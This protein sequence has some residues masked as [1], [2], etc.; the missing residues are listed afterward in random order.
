MKPLLSFL[1]F[2]IFS[3]KVASPS[4][5]T[6]DT[7]EN[8]PFWEW[9]DEQ[10]QT[11]EDSIYAILYPPVIAQKIDSSFVVDNSII[12]FSDDVI[13]RDNSHVPTSGSIDTSK[14]VGEINIKSGTSQTG[15]KTYEVPI[16]LYPG[17]NNFQPN[18]AL[19]YNSQQGNSLLGRGWN[20]SGLSIIN[21]TGRNRYYN[22]S[23]QRILMDKTDPFILDGNRLIRISSSDNQNIYESEQGNIKAIG[24]VSGDVITYFEV[25]YPNGYKGIFGN[26]TNVQNYLSYPLT[27]LSDLKGNTIEY[28][29]IDTDNHFNISEITYNGITIEFKYQPRQ[30][31]LLYYCV[32]YKLLESNLLKSITCKLASTELGKYSFDYIIS[33]NNESLLEKINYSVG[34]NSFNPLRFYYG[35]GLTATSYTSSNTQL[36]EWY[37]SEDKNMIKA[38]RGRFDYSSGTDGLIVFPNLNP[39]WEHFR[40][41][42]MFQ[43]S[44]KR[45]INNFKGDEKIFLYAGLKGEGVTPMPNLTTGAGFI[46]IICADI[47]G[48]QEDYVIKINNDVYT[49]DNVGAYY[50]DRVRFTI[51]K[52]NLYT[53]LTHLYTRTYQF[54]T[55]YTDADGGKSIQ[56]KFYYTGD[57]NGDGRMEI[58]AVSAHQPFNETSLPSQCYIFD[59]YHDKIIYEK[60]LFEYNVEFLGSRQQDVVASIN[61]TDKLF[62]FDYDGDGKTDI[63]HIDDYGVNIYS[64]RGT[65][66]QLSV[67]KEA[68]YIGL[69][70][71]GLANREI[72][73][74]DFNGDTLTDLLVS[75]LLNSSDWTIYY[76]KGNGQFIKSTFKGIYRADNDIN[77]LVQDVNSDGV[78][79][80]ITYNNNGFD[81]YLAK[82]NIISD[83]ENHTAYTSSESILVP[84]DL[85]TYGNFTQ[86]ISLKEGVVTKYAFSRNDNKENMVTGVMNSLG[87]IEK[88]EYNLINEENAPSGFYTKGNNANFPYI[89]ICEAIPV[90]AS[91]RTYMAG[92][93]VDNNSYT[94]SNAVFHKQ[95]LGFRGFEKITRYNKRGQAC[96]K[97]YTPL[98]N[99]LLISEVSPISEKKYTYDVNIGTNRISKINLKSKIEKDLLKG[100]STSTS[101]VYDSYG[102]PIE[103]TAEYSGNIVVKKKNEY[104]SNS[105]VADGYLLGFLTQQT[106]TVSRGDSSYTERLRIPVRSS[107]FKIVEVHYKNEKQVKQTAYSY[108]KHG[109]KTAIHV[110]QYGA[111]TQTTS[112]EYDSYGRVIKVTN[113]K[114]LSE[115]YSYNPLGHLLESTDYRGGISTYTYD[116][117]G[118][119]T[120]VHNP[121]NTVKKTIYTW[122]SEAPNG[123]YKII[124]S[125][126]GKPITT[127]VYDALNRE[128][129]SMECRFDGNYKK[130]DKLY[131]SFGN[132]Q[133]ESLP[134]IGDAASAWNTYEYDVYDR[135][136][137]ITE[138]SGK[139]TKYSYSGSRISYEKDKISTTRNYDAFGNLISVSD[140]NGSIVF[141]YAPDGQLTSV[142]APGS[143]N[144]SFGYDEYRRQTSLVDPSFGTISYEYDTAWNIA[145]E[146]NGNGETILKEYDTFGRLIKTTTA[147]FSTSYTYND[148]DELTEVITD[149]GSSRSFVYDDYGRL[150]ECKE[151]GI[152]GKWLQKNFSYAYGNVSEIKYTSQNGLLAT[153]NHI[154]SNGHLSEVKLNG[155]TTIY[156]LTKQNSFG[157]ATEIVTGNIS[158][159]YDYTEYAF[160]AYREAYSNNVVY[161][162]TSYSF[163]AETSNLLSRTDKTRNIAE[164]FAYDYL[165]R[166]TSYGNETA[167]Y[168]VK[169]NITNRSEIGSFEYSLEQKPYAISGVELSDNSIPL[170]NQ[171]ISYTSFGRPKTISEDIYSADFVYNGDYD[172]MRM[173]LYKNGMEFLTRYYLGDCY[174]LDK[175][176]S[177]TKEK[178]Y[179]FGGYYDSPVVLIKEGSSSELF[180]IIRDYLGSITHV[181]SSTGAVMQELSYDAWGRL[182]DPGTQIVYEPGEE[183]NL[184]LGR[185]YTGHEHIVEFGL[186]NMNA[187]L[188]DP[189]LGR[190]L[191]PD[192]YVQ[193]PDWAQNFNRYT[194]AMNNPLCYIDEDGEFFWFVIAGAALVGAVVNVATHWDEIKSAHG[195]NAFWKGAGYALVGAAAGGAGAAVGVWAALGAGGMLSVTAASLSS[196]T[197][198]FIPGATFGAASGAASE[199]V[200]DT[201]NALLE[202]DNLG[203]ALNKGIF[204]AAKGG[205]FG[206]LAGGLTGSVQALQEGKNFWNGSENRGYSV[207]FGYANGD[208]NDVRYIGITKREPYIRFN[209]HW[210][211]GTNRAFL[212][213]EVFDGTGNLT[214]LQARIME[215]NWINTYGLMKNGGTLYNL[216]NEISPKYWVKYGVKW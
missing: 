150:I 27:S 114:G 117:F 211:S 122:S 107:G 137:S 149:N 179:L 71:S 33:K 46:D 73:L 96:V 79:D 5:S 56:P 168:D 162:K 166:L 125:N 151:S 4:S 201:A 154:F 86:L 39:Y 123:L 30:D 119:E 87:L 140:R 48:S 69:T 132:L 169:G 110:T 195:W 131:D 129:R 128:V 23:N 65:G 108:D 126:T 176:E 43:H 210:N 115:E 84:I 205:F 77:F 75:P 191:S 141:K 124:R 182:R 148:K 18:L 203:N 142:I 161:H 136:R 95:G 20:I 204:G 10:Y 83:I 112:Y 145:K 52:S 207:Y 70:K 82:N 130:V 118:R 139:K 116:A 160:P 183:P 188:Y 138:A 47:S 171:D 67:E 88:N 32:G 89:N 74:G 66:D 133:K 92:N 105:K 209:E 63:C 9:T 31:P 62:V 103:E 1:V 172:R 215:Q 194:Y 177:S 41:P 12:A 135:I 193:M 53:G 199:F 196:A 127:E 3:F 190:F 15:A 198:G 78:A 206:G 175:T 45:F 2:I 104:D 178:L 6:S 25:F 181:V 157:Q 186:I 7:N 152:D 167:S 38:I 121:D 29:Y 156:K 58:L 174:E 21:R 42:T 197:A 98:R 165:N 144:T 189:A 102:Y 180:Y 214:K 158:R 134:F 113:P 90:I 184:F 13:S 51:Y 54:P 80:L 22:N 101:Y 159:K 97:T 24:Y 40:Y 61:N 64:F 94:Y 16:E 14:A 208:I 109:N 212:K 8:N 163:D 44:Q 153:E 216:R 146:T 106:V 36:Y 59:L 19:T 85:N 11:Y 26:K 192:P 35:E 120:S 50:Y 34:D 213:Y 57:F 155:T 68:T 91:T 76:S 202:G 49:P 170:R 164:S 28:S 72:L 99:S 187:R 185:G 173:R 81:T 93:L 60:E 55:I 100:F 17:M 147:E 111:K 37:E 143:V 200:L